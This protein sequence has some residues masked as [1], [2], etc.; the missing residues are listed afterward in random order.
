MQGADQGGQA[1]AGAAR[2]PWSQAV[3]VAVE[4]WRAVVRWAVVMGWVGGVFRKP[5]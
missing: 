2:W 3:K 4:I 1:I 5:C